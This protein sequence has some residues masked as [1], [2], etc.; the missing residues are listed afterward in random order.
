[1]M[2]TP[3]IVRLEALSSLI[4]RILKVGWEQ[5]HVMELSTLSAIW[6]FSRFRTALAQ[7][8]AVIERSRMN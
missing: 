5:T 6:C 1:M 7:P 8:T 2:T 3:N 4:K